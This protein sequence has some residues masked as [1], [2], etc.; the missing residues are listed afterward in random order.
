MMRYVRIVPKMLLRV[1]LVTS[2]SPIAVIGGASLTSSISLYNSS[3][4]FLLLFS[5]KALQ[6]HSNTVQ[7]YN[8]YGIN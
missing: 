8:V 6:I 3:A 7:V 2:N 1:D 4:T 5:A